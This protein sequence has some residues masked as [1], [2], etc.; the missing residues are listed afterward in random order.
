MARTQAADYDQRREGIVAAAA[1]LY[2]RRGFLGASI[3]DLAQACGSSKSLIYHYFS[4][5]EDILFEVMASHIEELR[6]A[7]REVEA[8][9]APPADKLRDLA[10]RFM[11]LYAGAA[12]R[13]KVLLNELGH[14]PPTRRDEIVSW[15]R[16][17]VS[18]VELLLTRLRPAL[19][20]RPGGARP[21]A[22]LFF[23]MIN[24]THTWYDP[25]GPA[26][27]DAI[28]DA[29][30]DLVLGGLPALL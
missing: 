12:A 11:A 19:A 26:A 14:L 4:A 13:Q 6:A 27:P 23:G 2:A 30:V 1:E 22:L 9:P 29:A 10:R 15:Q 16:E 5:K 25:A 8:S 7:V 28:A 24:W 3:A 21:I 20:D 18:A 17:L